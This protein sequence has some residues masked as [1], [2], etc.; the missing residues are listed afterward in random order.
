MG[1]RGRLVIPSEVRERSGLQEGSA[2]VLLETPGGLVLLTRSQ[3]QQRV[4]ADL[5]G[6]DL[7]EELLAERRGEAVT[8]DQT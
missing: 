1:D 4:R 6:L 5:G 2:L 8:E 3:L 7:V